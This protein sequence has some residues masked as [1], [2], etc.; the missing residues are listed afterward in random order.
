M[1]ITVTRKIVQQPHLH[2]VMDSNA[3][4]EIV[5]MPVG[6]AMDFMTAMML[7]MRS[8]VSCTPFPH[9]VDSNVKTENAFHP[10]SN[11]ITVMTVVITAMN[12][13]AVVLVCNEVL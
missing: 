5:L 6:D 7:V 11:V 3:I 4:T 10:G 8:I 9:V 1:A 13:M 12:T 2:H